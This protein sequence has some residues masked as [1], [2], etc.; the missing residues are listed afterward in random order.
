MIPGVVG[1]GTVSV[2]STVRA[3]GE[4]GVVGL[5]A[6]L[7]AS[8]VTGRIVAPL[9]RGELQADLGERGVKGLSPSELWPPGER[10]DASFPFLESDLKELRSKLGTVEFL[11]GILGTNGDC[12]RLEK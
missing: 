11:F 12:S 7:F 9:K 5:V 3:P 2:G 4:T 1:S 8:W 10:G 6:L